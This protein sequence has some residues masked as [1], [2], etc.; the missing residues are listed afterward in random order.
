MVGGVGPFT[1]LSTNTTTRKQMVQFAVIFL[2]SCLAWL[3][4]SACGT[5]FTK[6]TM[7][8]YMGSMLVLFSDFFIKRCACTQRPLGSPLEPTPLNQPINRT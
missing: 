5:D 1:I 8:V 3:E 2:Q 7:M 6:L 4:G